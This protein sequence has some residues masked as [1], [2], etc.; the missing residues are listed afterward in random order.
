MCN[1]D[2]WK[3]RHVCSARSA[4]RCCWCLQRLLHA[5]C[6]G[7]NTC[8]TDRLQTSPQLLK[9]NDNSGPAGVQTAR[10]ASQKPTPVA[11]AAPQIKANNRGH[12]CVLNADNCWRS[13]SDQLGVEPQPQPLLLRP[14]PGVTAQTQQQQRQQQQQV[15]SKQVRT[16]IAR[17]PYVAVCDCWL[18]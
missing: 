1:G 15:L 14:V 6:P 2:S 9:H 5:Q 17:G 10:R 11:A 12:C 3:G 7:P 16:C 13:S 4:A 8:F 18:Q